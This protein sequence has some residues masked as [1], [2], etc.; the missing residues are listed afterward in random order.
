MLGGS[1][2]IVFGFFFGGVV[3]NYYFAHAIIA[4]TS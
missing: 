1:P 3:D 2:P 4:V